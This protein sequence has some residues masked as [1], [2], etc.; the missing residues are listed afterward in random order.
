[1]QFINVKRLTKVGLLAGLL[2]SG[3][4]TSLAQ[5]TAGPTPR[6]TPATVISVVT[7]ETVTSGSGTSIYLNANRD[8]IPAI[9]Q[10]AGNDVIVL[11]KENCGAARKCGSHLF[12]FGS[13][14]PVGHLRPPL[15]RASR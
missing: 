4:G 3:T 5:Q 7:N 2:L 11:D 6:K 12:G 14:G 1:M 13:S 9:Q 8:V 10:T 15:S